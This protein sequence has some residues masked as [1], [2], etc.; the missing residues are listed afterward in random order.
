MWKTNGLQYAPLE[1]V[2]GPTNNQAP[3]IHNPYKTTQHLHEPP[4]ILTQSRCSQFL[5]D[6][7]LK[8]GT[9][10]VIDMLH[11]VIIRD[12]QSMGLKEKKEPFFQFGLEELLVFL[13]TVFAISLAI[14]SSQ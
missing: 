1:E 14:E 12:I 5:K 6:V 4:A 9:Q 13:V 10:G 11:P 8:H 3:Q 2:W 7:Y